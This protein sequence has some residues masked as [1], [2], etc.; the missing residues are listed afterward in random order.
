MSPIPLPRDFL[1]CAL[2]ASYVCGHFLLYAA[3]ARHAERLRTERGIFAWH[4]LS[5]ILQSAVLVL[6]AGHWDLPA[7][8]PSL[9]FAAALHGIYSLSFLELWSLTQ[10][11]YSLGILVHLSRA[12]GRATAGQLG[13][14]QAVGQSKQSAR[15]TDLARLGLVRPDGALTFPGRRAALPLR[16]IRWL[17]NGRTMN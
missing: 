10:G 4:V 6:A 15:R 1:L 8:R 9:V 16:A 13:R 14:L 2:S 12:G 5:Y 7:L 11:S 17:T 3:G